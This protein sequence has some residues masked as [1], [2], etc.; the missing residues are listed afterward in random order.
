MRTPALTIVLVLALGAAAAMQ[1]RGGGPPQPGQRPGPGPGGQLPPRAGRPPAEPLRGTA[2]M[3]GQVVAADTGSPIRRAQ[4]RVSAPGVES[5][6]ATTDAQGRFE[7]R[8]LPAGRYSMTASKGGFVSLQYGQR[9]PTESGTPIELADGQ[10]LDKLV[11]GLPRGSVITGR[12]TDE[13]GEPMAN[14]NVMAMR[15]G[16]QAGA[17]RLMPAP[18]GNTRDTTDDQGQFRLFGLPPGDY[19]V[20]AV[21]RTGEITDPSGGEA[22]GYA[23]TYYPGTPNLAEAQRVTLGL[24]QEN[25]N[26]SFGLISTSLVRVSGQVLTSTG[27][28]AG[29]GTVILAPPGGLGRGALAQGSGATARVDQTGS[30]RLTN[31]APGRYQ[32]QARTGQRGD[33]GFAKQEIVVGAE[34]VSGLVLI[35]A[36]GAR[37]TGSIVTDTGEPFP[38]RPQQVQVAAR[39]ADPDSQM[40]GG[41]AAAAASRIADNWTFELANVIEPRLIRASAP[42]GWTMKSVF[43]NGQ[44]ITDVPMEFPAGQTVTGVQ[45]VMTQKISSLTGL[46]TDDRNQPV[47][48][49]TVV[50]FPADEK[51]WT[52]QSRFIRAARPDQQGQFRIPSLPPHSGYL[53]IALQG[54]EDGQAGDPEFLATIKDAAKAFSLGD[55]ES[56]TV[57]AKLRVQ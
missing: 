1:G 54:L 22:S 26:V 31:V 27:G 55:G 36:P 20:S 51:L 47:L 56:K 9:R 6:L 42:Q 32:L 57:D 44:E 23:P 21:L 10:K 14:A 41:G 16:Y 37:V 39:P 38:I 13:F 8:D 49:A 25:S 4:V 48:D 45:I 5:R 28:A 3:R 19:Y 50:V 12:I 35:T 29:G 17:R 2:V 24:A 33:G 18:G 34:D 30:F 52:Y 7:I 40:P 11:M 46:V 43:L 53:M 15:Y